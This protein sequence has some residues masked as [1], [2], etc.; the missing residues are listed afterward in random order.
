[1]KFLLEVFLCLFFTFCVF[2]QTA[3]TAEKSIVNVENI[4]LM[5]DNGE[6]S[7]GAETE[8][9]KTS[10]FPIH[11]QITLDSVKSSTV[12]MILAAVTVNGLK[13]ETKILTV[14][15]KTNGEQNIVNFRGSPEKAWMA[16]KYR[17][18]IFI[19]NR[20]AG[21]KEFTIEKSAS[22]PAGQTNFT[23]PKPKP[24]T[25]PKRKN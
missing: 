16:G 8:I 25:K 6:G 2:G 15:Y 21:N 1:M 3:E 12:K 17:V 23:P 10:D 11:C 4:A 22:S 18:D 20:L 14:S 13:A 9:F 7:P 19:D 24:K 5:R